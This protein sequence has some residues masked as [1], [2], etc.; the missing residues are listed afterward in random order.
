MDVDNGGVGGGTSPGAINGLALISI[1]LNRVQTGNK[2]EPHHSA[3]LLLKL[4]NE[5]ESA[6]KR[7]RNMRDKG[8]R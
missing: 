1:V 8:A 2:Q 6:R 4:V 7:E 3:L 5:R